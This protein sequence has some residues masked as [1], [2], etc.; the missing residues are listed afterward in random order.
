MSEPSPTSEPEVVEKNIL[1][2]VVE[3]QMNLFNSKNSTN[4]KNSV[5]SK[6]STLNPKSKYLDVILSNSIYVPLPS[7]IKLEQE[8]E[9]E[10]ENNIPRRN[11][12][13]VNIKLRSK[14]PPP[15]RFA[16]I[17]TTNIECDTTD[18]KLTK[19]GFRADLP[20]NLTT[21]PPCPKITTLV[22]SLITNHTESEN[23]LDSLTVKSHPRSKLV[24]KPMF[25]HVYLNNV[26]VVALI[27]PGSAVNLI[28]KSLYEANPHWPTAKIDIDL[29]FANG[30]ESTSHIGSYNNVVSANGFRTG[31]THFIVSPFDTPLVDIILGE[32]FLTQNNALMSFGAVKAVKF[33]P[34][35]SVWYDANIQEHQHDESFGICS[36]QEVAR[37]FKIGARTKQ[38]AIQTALLF[39]DQTT[40]KVSTTTSTDFVPPGS[41]PTTTECIPHPPAFTSLLHDYKDAFSRTVPEPANRKQSAIIGEGMEIPLI[42]GALPVN[43]RGFNPSAGEMKIINYMVADLVNLGYVE[44][45]SPH[46]K[47]GAPIMLVKKPGDRLGVS[48]MF[49]LVT[50]FRRVNKLTDKTSSAYSPPVINDLFRQLAGASVFSLMDLVSGFYQMPLHPNSRDMSTFVCQTPTGPVKYRFKVVVMGLTGA[51]SYFQTQMEKVME[52][53]PG[54]I[55]YL[56]DIMV[57]SKNIDEH[58]KILEQVFARMKENGLY[59]HPDKCK[60][61]R[62]TI[63]FLGMKITQNKIMPADDKYKALNEYEEPSTVPEVRRFLG[64]S[65]YLAM[66]IPNFNCMTACLSDLLTKEN[67]KRTFVFPLHC[68]EAFN[69]IR[70]A[71]NK[72]SGLRIPSINAEL[73]LECDASSLGVGA[74]LY[75]LLDGI[76]YP[77]YFISKKFSGAER[78]YAPRDQEALAVVY[79]LIKFRSYL[80]LSFFTL[81]SDHQSLQYFQE[82][83][84]LHKRDWR[85]QELMSEFNYEHRYRKGELM[86]VPDALSRSFGTNPEPDVI[87]VLDEINIL[88]PPSGACGIEFT[89]PVPVNT[90]SR[91]DARKQL[92]LS[93]INSTENSSDSQLQQQSTDISTSPI[94][95]SIDPPFQQPQQTVTEDAP[96]SN[97]AVYI[98][99][100]ISPGLA[101]FD[102]NLT[103]NPNQFNP[104]LSKLLEDLVEDDYFD[105]EDDDI[106]QPPFT[107]TTADDFSGLDGE[108]EESVSVSS[109]NVHD[110]PTFTS[111]SLMYSKNKFAKIKSTPRSPPPCQETICKETLTPRSRDSTVLAARKAPPT[112]QES[113]PDPTVFK[114]GKEPLLSQ[115]CVPGIIPLPCGNTSKILQHT[116]RNTSLPP[117]TI[118]VPSKSLCNSITASDCYDTSPSPLCKETPF[119]NTCGK[120]TLLLRDRSPEPSLQPFEKETPLLQD[121]VPGIIPPS[122]VSTSKT[123][124]HPPGNF[125]LPSKSGS[126]I[127]PFEC[128]P[129]SGCNNNPPSTPLLWKETL[130]CKETLTPTELHVP[131]CGKETLSFQAS[132]PDSPVFKSGKEPLLSQGC[133]PGIIPLPCGNTSKLQNTPENFSLKL[134]PASLRSNPSPGDNVQPQP[135]HKPTEDSGGTDQQPDFQRRQHRNKLQQRAPFCYTIIATL[136]HD[137]LTELPPLYDND[138]FFSNIY[139]CC[140]LPADKLSLR[141]RASVKYYSIVDKCLYY[142]NCDDNKLRLCVPLSANNFIR[143]LIL[144]E[145]H[146]ALLHQ[147]RDKT[148]NRIAATYYWPKLSKDVKRY[149]TACN[150]CRIFKSRQHTNQGLLSSLP[151][152]VQ[153]FSH[154]HIDFI[155]ALQ[156]SPCGHDQILVVVCEVSK[157]LYL[158]PA[159][160]THRS[161]DSSRLLFNHVICTHGPPSA[162]IS[163]MDPKFISAVYKSIM[164]FFN[165]ERQMSTSHN[166]NRNGA[167][168]VVI[169]TVEILLRHVLSH[170]PGRSFVDFLGLVAY[171]YNSSIHSSIG[172]TPFLA[173]FGFEPVNPSLLLCDVAP[174]PTDDHLPTKSD[175]KLA[176]QEFIQHQQAVIR[177]VKDALQLSQRTMEVFENSTRKDVQYQPGQWVFLNTTNLDSHYF[178]RD[179]YKLRDRFV[180]PFQIMEQVSS[181]NYRLRLPTAMNKLPN[182]FHAALLWYQHPSQPDLQPLKL[183]DHSQLST[184]GSNIPV[185]PPTGVPAPPLTR[186]QELAALDS[187]EF[188]VESILARK[189]S[190][191]RGYKYLVKWVG[192]PDSDN[193]WLSRKNLA[194]SGMATAVDNF[195]ATCNESAPD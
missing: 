32:V 95:R 131:T 164:D 89:A 14:S 140:Q 117:I 126:P 22:C 66:F 53:I 105:G 174:P 160:S 43:V 38:E 59:F 67:T 191:G 123:Q 143:R 5:S 35:G 82:Q 34:S 29:S 152:P 144:F 4:F 98:P 111:S 46:S 142:S 19:L 7:K 139:K 39:I 58:I 26:P 31:N 172:V 48:N 163:D 13:N 41:T 49:R 101:A 36:V 121:C 193:Q 16:S 113:V 70:N 190:G 1:D 109:I 147:S 158:I 28:S 159:K 107:T 137:W 192:Y 128:N 90:V 15:P 165:I 45:S 64:F 130:K 166:H 99:H 149:V 92:I 115:G 112:L 20:D 178:A 80:Y 3:I 168:E 125:S 83:R 68:R 135:Q 62:N 78:N 148:Y 87:G 151:I 65:Q 124:Q 186:T 157:F 133:V 177:Q 52:G 77:V 6:N 54:V 183:P 120:E 180:G 118:G 188:E 75:E 8:E 110:P 57:F 97:P 155:T 88:R 114:S 84:D 108:G 195:D 50:D 141:Q 170:Y 30:E 18:I 71:L 17:K 102:F 61:L 127:S 167:C 184:T 47:W 103:V 194:T 169:K 9:E 25:V 189:R 173:L 129:A 21:V 171:I 79:S 76:L 138:I 119:V 122:R 154:L 185:V 63:Q 136:N 94:D 106:Y 37:I 73:V 104:K 100:N 56:D 60:F 11:R 69:K 162:I 156:L 74:C 93:A 55:V 161:I 44:P 175:D 132:E 2:G 85:W 182:V 150:S 23:D 176:V 145:N 51:P 86:V 153:R 81:Y 146:D 116:P 134:F 42:P 96:A 91:L 179:E 181:Y 187:D 27:D 72:S 24:G 40:N 33:L 12:Q 10:N